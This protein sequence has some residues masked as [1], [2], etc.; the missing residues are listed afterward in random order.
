M[1][2][3][4][5]TARSIATLVRESELSFLAGSIAFFA[6]FSLVPSLLLLVALGSLVGGEQFVTRIV[7]LF[8]TSLSAGGGAVIG[9]ALADPTGQVGASIVGVVG[10]FWSA[11]KVFRAIDLAFD[12]IYTTDKSTSLPQQLRDAT[13]VVVSIGGG[14]ILLLIVQITLVRLDTG[15]APYSSLLGV[16]VLLV[17]LLIVLAPLYY[18]MPPVRL[19]VRQV[20]PGTITAVVGLIALQQV[21][22]VYASFAGQ[23]RA[24]G[25]IGAVLLFLLW[26]YVGALV[27]LLGAVVN[28]A[29][30][31]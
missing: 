24:Y 1:D 25:F 15:F 9:E 29:V 13:V 28:V 18:V 5:S 10:L 11:L 20:V 26:L 16:P 21:F 14:I 12:R 4:V 17:G 2:D 31:R 19:S 22:H 7:R 23:Y 3:T 8:E 6:F 30:A 27:L